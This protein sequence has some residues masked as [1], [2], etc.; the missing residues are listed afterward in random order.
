MN[1]WYDRHEVL[2]RNLDLMEGMTEFRRNHLLEGINVIIKD[3]KPTL[4]DDYVLDFPI[5]FS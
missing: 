4:F 3:S 1:R 2:G 5:N